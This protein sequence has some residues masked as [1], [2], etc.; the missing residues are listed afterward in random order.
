MDAYSG[1]GE[2]ARNICKA[3]DVAGVEVVTNIVKN[4]E[5]TVDLGDNQQLARNK[6]NLDLPYNIKI[7]HTTPDVVRAGMEPMKYHIF[8]Q[9]WE[10]DKLPQWWVWE[11]NHSVDEIWT[12]CEWNKRVFIDSGINRPVWVC[13]QPINTDIPEGKKL[14][15]PGQSGFLFGSMFQW[16]ERKNPKALIQSFCREF[17]GVSGV[18]LLIKTYKE[19]FTE[20]EKD[21]IIGEMR[22]W[23]NE[24]ELN[25]PPPVYLIP[26]IMSKDEINSFY[27]TIDCFVSAHR[28]EG[29]GVPI[30]EAMAAG[31]PVISTNLGGIHEH[32]PV[33]YW[34]PVG[35]TIIPVFNM[36]WT[37]W[38]GPDQNWADV[39]QDQLQQRMRYVF[40]HQ[41]EAKN[42]GLRAK[43]FISN[44][45]SY[46]TVGK[47]MKERLLHI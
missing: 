40:E 8:H 2:A 19:R 36:N 17:D 46:E 25:N 11:L 41:E 20:Q 15:I 13:P 42:K 1:M 38:Y 10:T 26:D 39:N 32:V 37:P 22:G 34:Y 29:F 44:A 43:K 27:Q 24:L 5:S 47:K 35:Y 30:G 18:S 6:N 21:D 7:F 4:I 31:K 16:I 23:K 14:T 45:L 28:G 9:F 12:G 33:E 3:L